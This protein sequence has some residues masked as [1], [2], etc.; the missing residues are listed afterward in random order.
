MDETTV[1]EYIRASF[2]GVET[3]STGPYTFFFYGSDRKLPF[4]TLANADDPY[5]HASEL[6]RPGV[7]RLNIS[8]SRHTYR[9]VF[10]PESPRLGQSGVVETGHDFATLDRL[11]PHPVYAPQS[12][13]CVLNPSDETFGTVQPLLSEA[14][15][16]AVKRA[17]RIAS[18]DD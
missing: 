14:H 3:A 2:P 8:V 1:S 11:L 16:R 10:G 4:A 6:D 9:S 15:D 7:Y 5:D 13:I 17:K 18:A 12:W